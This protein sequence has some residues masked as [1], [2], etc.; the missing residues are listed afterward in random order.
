MK[1]KLKDIKTEDGVEGLIVQSPQRCNHAWQENFDVGGNF[2][3]HCCEAFE[4]NK[5]DVYDYV[6][7]II[8]NYQPHEARNMI[9]GY[10]YRDTEMV[11]MVREQSDRCVDTVILKEN[12]S[13]ALRGYIYD[14]HLPEAI[15]ALIRSKDTWVKIVYVKE[16]ES[17]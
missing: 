10:V 6:I 17:K 13:K 16:G 1:T 8:K 11:D 3:V 15:D 4:E 5:K 2:C 14:Q 12:L 7:S 9:N